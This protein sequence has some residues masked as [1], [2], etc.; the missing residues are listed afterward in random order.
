MIEITITTESR[1]IREILYFAHKSQRIKVLTQLIFLFVLTCSATMFSFDFNKL[2]KLDEVIENYNIHADTIH[3]N[4]INNNDV[5]II[6][7]LGNIGIFL[8]WLRST[9]ALLTLF[10]IYN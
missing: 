5:T 7:K 8:L 2:L 1:E 6:P 10:I 9:E 3:F 4:I